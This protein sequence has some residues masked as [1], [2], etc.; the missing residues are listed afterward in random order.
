M[1]RFFFILLVSLFTLQIFGSDLVLI[2]TKN[3]EETQQ[4]FKN[5]SVTVHF[6][7]DEFVI[8]TIGGALKDGFVLL[9]EKP[10]FDRYSY[11][12]VYVDKMVEK[13]N[14]L[15]QISGIADVLLD[16]GAQ[17]IVRV[18]ESSFGQLHP[19]KNDGMVRIYDREVKLP[20]T[21]FFTGASRFDPDPFIVSLLDE[22]SGPNITA[23]VQHLEDY[24][25]RNAYAPESV[26]AQNW[27]KEQFEAM[28]LPVELMDFSMPNGA[29]S[30]NVI[31]TLEGTKYPDEYVVI[32]GHYDSYTYSGPSPGADDNAS[33]TSGVMEVARILSQYEFD[34]TIIF[35]AFSGE[36][37]G[38][39]GSAAYAAD[40]AQQGMNIHGYLNMDMIAYLQPGSYIHTDMIY[41]AS[42]QPLADYYEMICGIYLPDF[43]VEQGT[44]V[45]GDS[46]HTSFN[47]N[48]Y[49]GIFP[50]EDSQNYSPHIHTSND[51][52]G[53]SYNNEDQAVE[54][55]KA[56]LATTVS[57]A[58]RALPPQ[59]LT[60]LPGDQQVSLNWDEMF[61]IDYFNIYRNDELI[62]TTTDLFYQDSDVE[63]GVQY[64]YYITAIY[65]DSGN[66]S[67]PS[68]LVNAT[69]MPPIAFP[70]M[71]DFENG[72]PY[73]NFEETWGIS[74]QA[75][76][77]PS[78]SVS[79]SPEGNYGDDLDIAATLTPFSLAGY[80]D[81]S[82]SFWAKW[83]L[84]TNYDYMWLEI[85]T[86]GSS[87]TELD[88]F[89]GLQN[90][91][92][93][94]TYSLNNYLGQNYVQLRFRFFSDFMVTREG[95]YIDDFEIVV[96][97]GM[98]TQ[99]VPL[100]AG[101]SGISSYLAPENNDVEDMLASVADDIIIVQ[102]MENVWWP[103]QNINTIG[104]WNSHSGYKIKMANTAVLEIAAFNEASKTIELSEGW[105][106]MPVLSTWDVACEDV[107]ANV[108]SN[109]L[110]VKDVAGMGVFWPSENIQTLNYLAPSKA[111]M[112]K[113]NAAVSISFDGLD[114]AQNQKPAE[115]S[116]RID[117]QM[118][119]PTGNSH[120]LAIPPSL[121]SIFETGDQIGVFNSS[122][123]CTGMVQVDDLNQ[124]IPVVISGNDS[125]TTNHD[126]MVVGEM[127]A[128]KLFRPSNNQQYNLIP[129]F[130]PSFPNQEIYE[131]EGLSKLNQLEFDNTGIVEAAEYFNIHPN[132][133][134]DYLHVRVSQNS[135]ANLEIF[136]L[137]GR[138]VL[139]TIVEG[140]ATIATQSLKSGVYTIK[141][142]GNNLSKIEKLIIQ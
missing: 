110:I 125:I 99:S 79:E 22:V 4:L 15:T 57:M 114:P 66:E 33:G 139:Q 60:A 71:L 98:M 109:I 100:P 106:L 138:R 136:D 97:G 87:W 74:N 126:G 129:G 32:G 83:D 105:N 141:I 75:A 85:T 104:N 10:Q 132:P 12:V 41:P 76:Y 103:A 96:E 49:M 30:D 107:F 91:W 65:T 18:D 108:M 120:I 117:W 38:L 73:W 14:Y 122:G 62:D 16:N 43:V 77:S 88:E 2:P 34:R 116:C 70:L 3:F 29:A 13:S 90:S 58:N 37:Y 36:E 20:E 23:V 111:Y 27:I 113:T 47:N 82:V 94:K 72:A 92:V 9:D 64:T 127:M 5:P 115:S 11:Y 42:A 140:T 8:A 52:V 17:L 67:E 124:N 84:E 112:V 40:C 25:T 134:S 68:N 50:F 51:L 128:F 26:L 95:M 6:Y 1:K 21:E 89:N 46:D 45:G 44:L 121:L 54:F 133:A 81:A 61:D 53:P 69:P 59:N 7:R 78:H 35:C 130:D 31:A 119:E 55:T 142:S 123:Y 86:N 19:A 137:K 39:Y 63:N 102:D 48:G 24:G 135:K 93:N 28:D 56:I 101:W 131:H 118:V 80:T